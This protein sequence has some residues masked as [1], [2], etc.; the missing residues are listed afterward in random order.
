MN[1]I[2]HIKINSKF[3]HGWTIEGDNLVSVWFLGD[4]VPDE[5]YHED[6]ES[7]DN[8]DDDE[9]DDDEEKEDDDEEQGE[10]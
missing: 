4:R 10:K 9:E 2:T 3:L 5:L 6:D 7:D 8:D 1:F